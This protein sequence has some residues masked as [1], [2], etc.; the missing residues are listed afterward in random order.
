MERLLGLA[1]SLAA[2]VDY[3]AVYRAHSQT[4]AELCHGIG[5]ALGLNDHALRRLTI[6]GL[7][8]DVGKLQI[9]DAILNKPARLTSS[10]YDVIKH[11]PLLG[12]E[13]LLALG[14]PDEARWVL[15]HHERCD[16][17]GYPTGLSG[18]QIPLGARILLAADAWECMTADRPYRQGMSLEDAAVEML[19]CVGTQFDPQVAGA[20]LE[21]TLSPGW[22]RARLTV[23]VNR[24]AG[25]RGLA[26]HHYTEAAA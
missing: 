16:G 7:L 18:E 13:T 14:L 26:P 5:L 21:C 20:L 2:A 25:R 8:H 22:R 12:H 1:L 19:S 10:E 23:T 9:A 3:K 11:H 24:L 17:Q 15:H 6:A 4:V